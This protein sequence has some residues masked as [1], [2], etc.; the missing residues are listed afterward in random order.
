MGDRIKIRFIAT[1]RRTGEPNRA[2]GRLLSLYLIGFFAKLGWGNW[3]KSY[4]LSLLYTSLDLI[5]QK[6]DSIQ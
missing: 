5:F 6:S 3:K 4:F 1:V 2:E